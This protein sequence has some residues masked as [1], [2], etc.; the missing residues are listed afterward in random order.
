MD[1][2]INE[3]L[4]E[5]KLEFT[6]L[7]RQLLENY[8]SFEYEGTIDPTDVNLKAEL[9]DLHERGQLG[10]LFTSEWI[11]SSRRFDLESVNLE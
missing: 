4:A 10:L 7:T 9:I 1:E 6:P 3:Q 2:F 8:V 11:Y 5:L